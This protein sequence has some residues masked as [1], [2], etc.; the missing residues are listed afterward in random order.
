[1]S[2]AE[3]QEA[4]AAAAAAAAAGGGL[5]LLAAVPQVQQVLQ[6]ESASVPKYMAVLQ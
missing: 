1:M 2:L 5:L 4:A 6:H 3:A